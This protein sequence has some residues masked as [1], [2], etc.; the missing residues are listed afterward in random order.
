MSEIDQNLIEELAYNKI[1]GVDYGLKRTGLAVCD[2]LWIA[3]KTLG[4]LDPS[5][6]S[7]FWKKLREI[8][9]TE[10]IRAI[11]VGKPFREDGKTT[12]ITKAID[13]FAKEA[14]EKLKLRVFVRDEAKTSQLAVQTMIEIGKK[15]KDRKRKGNVDAIAAAIILRNFLDEL[16]FRRSAPP[17]EK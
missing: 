7:D 1:M 4:I 6:K 17:R 8:V 9:E 10:E 12:P 15:K 16:D 3:I 14:K 13:E 2:E 11:V 5:D